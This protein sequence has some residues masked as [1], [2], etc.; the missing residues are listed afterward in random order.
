MIRLPE[1]RCV[2]RH[3]VEE[4]QALIS[5]ADLARDFWE[6]VVTGAS[7]FDPE[8]EMVV[9]L[10]MNRK[11]RVVGW[12]LVSLGSMTASI[13]HPREVLRAVLVGG[14]AGFMLM[15]N[16]PSGDPS[17]SSADVQITSVINKAAKV[18]EVSFVD[19][20]IVGR[21]A[22]DALGRGYYSFREAGLI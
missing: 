19:H 8:K 1:F 7:W 17:P 21:I 22:C 2:A 10:V 12:N 3:C 16:H 15:H 9:V 5:R 13:V 11:N 20:V 6:N 18:V 4:E 14:G